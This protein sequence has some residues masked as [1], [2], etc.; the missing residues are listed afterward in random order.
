S[1]CRCARVALMPANATSF[2]RFRERRLGGPRDDGAVG[3]ETRSVARTIPGA[4]GGIPGDQAAHVGADRGPPRRDAGFVSI[5]RQPLAVHVEPLSGTARH[6]AQRFALRA[7]D[8]IA[9][10]VVRVVLVL[11]QVVPQPA[12]D[13]LAIDVE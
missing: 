6:R 4:F 12:A 8:P 7:G 2:F 13:L 9:S 10:E 1:A 3:L 5:D 11:T